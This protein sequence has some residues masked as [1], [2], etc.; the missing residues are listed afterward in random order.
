MTYKAKMKEY[1]EAKHLPEDEGTYP[2]ELMAQITI[3]AF[4]ELTDRI[5]ELEDKL[6][7]A[8]EELR[9]CDNDLK[10]ICNKMTEIKDIISDD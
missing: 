3:K 2:E 8:D 9:L 6:E 1:L 5:Q 7:D 4:D 10:D